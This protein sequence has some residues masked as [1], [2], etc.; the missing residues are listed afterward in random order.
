MKITERITHA[1]NAFKGNDSYFPPAEE[2]IVYGRPRRPV[3]Y[4]ASTSRFAASIFTRIALDVAMTNF[5]HVKIEKETEDRNVVNSGLNYCLTVEANLDQSAVSF[6]YDVAYS[7]LDEGY[8]AIVPVDTTINP[9]VSGSFDVE[10]MRVAPITG[11]TNKSVQVDLY[12]EN[13][14][15]YR[16]IWIPKSYTAIIESP[17]YSIINEPNSTLQRLLRKM[18]IVDQDEA[19]Y[20]PNRLDIILQMPQAVRTDKQMKDAQA[21]IRNVESQLAYGKNGI[22]YIDSNEKI[23]QLNRPANSQ[24]NESINTLKEEFYNQLGLTQAVFN[25]T[26]TE[27]Q[28]RAYYNRTIDPILRF[29]TKE[30]ERKF[31][32]KTARTQGHAIETYRNMLSL[33]SAEQL[34]SL[35]DTLRRNEIATSNEVRDIVGLKR[36]NDPLADEL[37]NPNL[38]QKSSVGSAAKAEGEHTRDSQNG[39]EL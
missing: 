30:M 11:W 29:I 26:A 23:T 17:L 3:V 13:C 24:I 28:L 18:A 15:E 5:S 21:R 22:A 35:G 39:G 25:G 4:R 32:T 34:A 19:A 14:G 31:L 36:S 7:L 2:H 37:R 8:I 6:I 27:A 16:K 1:W 20:S 9:K 33:V 38:S 12:D 10:T